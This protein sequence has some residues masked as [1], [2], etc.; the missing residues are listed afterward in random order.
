MVAGVQDEAAIDSRSGIGTGIN[1]DSTAGFQTE[2]AHAGLH[3]AIAVDTQDIHIFLL[4]VDIVETAG[5]DIDVTDYLI[6][7]EIGRSGG[8]TRAAANRERA[9]NRS[10]GDRF[11]QKKDALVDDRFTGKLVPP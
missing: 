8:G 4:S 5:I 2:I 11:I 9:W 1:V 3:T 6:A 10:D 7:V